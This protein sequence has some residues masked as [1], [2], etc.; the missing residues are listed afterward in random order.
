MLAG[1]FATRS[2]LRDAALRRHAIER[3]SPFRHAFAAP[4]FAADAFQF[5]MFRHCLLFIFRDATPLF[6][7]LS[8]PDC[9]MPLR[10]RRRYRCR[11]ICRHI[12]IDADIADFSPAMMR[13]LCAAMPPAALPQ[14]HRYGAY[15]DALRLRI[16]KATV[17]RDMIRAY[18]RAAIDMLPTRSRAMRLC[19][20]DTWRYADA[21]VAAYDSAA[22]GKVC[23]SK[24]ARPL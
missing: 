16:A 13:A 18:M 10:F 11:F 8:M 20:A 6:L 17:L 14:Q 3:H 7:I 22:H 15:G 5:S 1:A 4:V 12:F 23:S 2:F 9:L 24:R 21:S 19:Y